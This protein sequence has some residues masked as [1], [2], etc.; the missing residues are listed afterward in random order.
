M[1]IRAINPNEYPF[2]DD[3]TCWREPVARVYQE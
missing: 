2:L 3:F 1:N